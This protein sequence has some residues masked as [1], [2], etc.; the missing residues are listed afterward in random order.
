MAPQRRLTTGGMIRLFDTNTWEESK[1]IHA[2]S[3]GWS[4]VDTD[5]S[6]D[7]RF[8]IYSSWSP[9]GTVQAANE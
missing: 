6:P 4:V 3:T 2:R 8:L 7:R 1:R 5:Y 9:Y